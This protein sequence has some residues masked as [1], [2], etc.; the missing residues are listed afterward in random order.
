M[1][2]RTITARPAAGP[3]TPR[4]EPLSEATIR[5]PTIPAIIPEKRGAP[6]ARA[7]PK[8][9]GNA[10]RNTTI[11]AGKS[12]LRFLNG[13]KFIVE[14]IICEAEQEPAFLSKKLKLRI[15]P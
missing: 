7:I 3:L 5:P 8:H 10:T 13:L 15:T 6:L 11:L 4:G 9:S 1:A 14:Y 2:V 12:Y